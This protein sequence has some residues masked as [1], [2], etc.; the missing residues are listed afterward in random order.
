MENNAFAL[1][2]EISVATDEYAFEIN[3]FED[4]AVSCSEAVDGPYLASKAQRMAFAMVP[5]LSCKGLEWAQRAGATSD[6]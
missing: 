5:I 2:T 6:R 4:N 1:L 3:T